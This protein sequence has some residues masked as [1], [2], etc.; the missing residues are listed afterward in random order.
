MELE[1]GYLLRCFFQYCVMA[2]WSALCAWCRT[3][4]EQRRRDWRLCAWFSTVMLCGSCF[5]A[6]LWAARMTQLDSAFNGNDLFLNRNNV[7]GMALLAVALSLRVVF[8]VTYAIEF[9]CLS[10]AK[11]MVLDRMSDFALPQE[12]GVLRRWVVG[13]SVVT[14]VVV[15]GNAAGLAAN[16]AAAVHYQR[17]ADSASTSSAFFAANNTRADIE[18][19]ATSQSEVQRAGPTVSVQLFCCR[20]AAVHCRSRSNVRSP[21][22]RHYDPIRSPG[23]RRCACY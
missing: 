23:N 13:G 2:G 3:Q 18:Y 5:G 21:Y 1:F 8:T 7:Q 17:A 16:V 14:A 19:F 20:G 6:D 12:G 10:K 11:L 22:P 4:E 9:L 15:L